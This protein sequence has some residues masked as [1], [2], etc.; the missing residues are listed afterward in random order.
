MQRLPQDLAWEPGVIQSVR[1]VDA[2]GGVRAVAWHPPSTW[3]HTDAAHRPPSPSTPLSDLLPHPSSPA[4][5]RSTSD[6]RPRDE[7]RLAK[8]GPVETLP[9]LSLA[10]AGRHADDRS[11]VRRGLNEPGKCEICLPFADPRLCYPPD[12][13][14]IEMGLIGP[15]FTARPRWDWTA[16]I[17]RVKCVAVGRAVSTLLKV[18]DGVSPRADGAGAASPEDQLPKHGRVPQ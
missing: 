17:H 16:V 9:I 10:T 4:A 8:P 3:I 5:T 11:P 12:P 1:L 14:P 13:G 18:E 7:L 2:G 15:I 6:G